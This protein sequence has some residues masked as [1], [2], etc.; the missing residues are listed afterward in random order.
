MQPRPRI[1][2]FFELLKIPDNSFFSIPVAYYIL[3]NNNNKE[4][5]TFLLLQNIPKMDPS[6]W[7][8]EERLPQ[9]REESWL[10]KMLSIRS[11]KRQ[12]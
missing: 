12:P 5:L 4:I 11:P 3:N 2:R 6:L 8:I 7:R 1:T 9:I 10:C